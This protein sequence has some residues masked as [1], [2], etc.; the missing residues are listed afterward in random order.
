MGADFWGDWGTIEMAAT[1]AGPRVSLMLGDLGRQLWEFGN[2]MPGGLGVAWP[3]LRGQWSLALGADR[4]HIGHD[5]SDPL[6]REATA[7]VSWMSSLPARLTPAAGLHHGLGS[8]QRI[9]RR[10]DRGVGRVSIEPFLEIAD[11][12]LKVADGGLELGD[13]LWELSAFRT[14]RC[15]GGGLVA[16][17]AERYGFL[18]G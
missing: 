16:H 3:G 2:L 13:P 6:Q 4:V 11:D 14:S 10:R 1:R 8:T 9:G 12:G 15:W 18:A 5:L 17:A 7:M